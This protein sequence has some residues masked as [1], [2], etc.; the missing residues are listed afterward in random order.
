MS[1]RYPVKRFKKTNL[2]MNEIYIEPRTWKI[3]DFDIGEVAG[4]KKKLTF[5]VSKSIF[6]AFKL[7][8]E[9]LL[10]K[11][12]EM[13]FK[14][15]KIKKIFKNNPQECENVKNLLWK[16]Y[17]KLKNIYLTNILSSEYP[18]ISWN[19]FSIFCNKCK[20]PDKACNLSTID[21]VFIATNVNQNIQG[22]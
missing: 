19:D 15:T 14:Y 20:I 3:T 16:N 6:K 4:V 13:D 8:N 9:D 22:A 12:F 17:A 10:K 1:D 7:E 18:V 2:Y 11:I 5:D 21:R